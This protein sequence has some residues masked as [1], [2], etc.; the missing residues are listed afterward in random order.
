MS[1]LSF[2]AVIISNGVTPTCDVAHFQW[3]NFLL[4]YF[5]GHH[6]TVPQ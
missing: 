3:L 2:L 4:N 5:L 6:L 1:L